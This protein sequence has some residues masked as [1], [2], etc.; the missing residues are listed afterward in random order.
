MD[1][2][3]LKVN[4]LKEE[5]AKRNLPT[6]GLKADL[7]SRLEKALDDEALGLDDTTNITTSSIAPSPAPAP[8]APAAAPAPAPK[9]V[10]SAP[11]SDLQGSS[12]SSSSFSGAVANASTMSEEERIAARRA[13]F[14][15]VTVPDVPKKSEAKK[16]EAKESLPSK[17][18]EAAIKAAARLQRFTGGSAVASDA[19]PVESAEEERKRKRAE[20]FGA[21]S[22]STVPD[23]EDLKREARR[24]KFGAI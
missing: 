16:S 13:R 4:E 1:A 11:I 14:G 17:K 9:A 19:A 12:S 3:K 20:R 24:A 15:I 6:D 10:S 18:E 2:R 5:L 8:H 7:V 23:E 22:T 21:A